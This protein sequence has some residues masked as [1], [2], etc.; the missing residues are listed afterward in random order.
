MNRVLFEM[1]FNVLP[2]ALFENPALLLETLQA[3]D[4]SE[5]LQYTWRGLAEQFGDLTACEGLEVEP[6]ALK[7]SEGAFLVRYP[8]GALRPTVFFS[9]LFQE[10][11]GNWRYFT[12]ESDDDHPTRA[13]EWLA[14]GSRWN[15]GPGSRA[16]SAAFLSFVER[17][18][19]RQDL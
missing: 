19:R 3:R 8:R 18:V 13:S 14:D 11:D 17:L 5:R 7:G 4:A 10:G 16:H 12:L 15:L 1:A 9:L 6:T 2:T